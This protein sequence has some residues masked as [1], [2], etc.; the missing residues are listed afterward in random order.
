[1]INDFSNNLNT[2]NLYL[3]IKPSPSY[4]IMKGFIYPKD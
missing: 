2:V 3:K 1:M 4:K